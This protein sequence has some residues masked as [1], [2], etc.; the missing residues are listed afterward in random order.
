MASQYTEN[1]TLVSPSWLPLLRRLKLSKGLT[2]TA[3]EPQQKHERSSPVGAWHE[4]NRIL[5]SGGSLKDATVLLE[6]FISSASAEDYAQVQ[7]SEVEAWSLLG[8]T[9]A[10]NEMEEKALSAFEEGREALN[11]VDA[12]QINGVGELLT[13]SPL[14]TQVGPS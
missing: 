13:A 14:P 12:T 1:M 10:M 8:R 2:R 5:S 9:H 6:T 7:A 4:A 11:G 3:V